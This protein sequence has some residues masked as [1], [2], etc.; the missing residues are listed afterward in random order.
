MVQVVPQYPQYPQYP[1]D[2]T[3]L[4]RQTLRLYGELLARRPSWA[5][6]LVF[7]C[8]EGAAGTGLAAAGCIAGGT[9]LVVDPD[10][11]GVK[12]AM[13]QGGVDFVVNTLDEALRGLKN[14]IRQGRPLGVALIAEPEVVV[15]EMVERGVLPDLLVEIGDGKGWLEEAGMQR[16][17][18]GREAGGV[19]AQSGVLER[20]LAERGWSERVFEAGTAA[21]MRAVDARVM[22]GL[23]VEDSVRR[24][25][26]QRIS[27]YQ[28]GSGGRVVWVG[29]HS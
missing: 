21:E 23:A 26:V 2:A 13:R 27:Q 25:W 22:E 10:A 7:A 1:L 3:G 28:R 12:A 4:Q 17:R 9:S 11:A 16:L 6:K 18:L 20:W 29:G 19:V 8:G 14:Q 5:G 15:E 24:L